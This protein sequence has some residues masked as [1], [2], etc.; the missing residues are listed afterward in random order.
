MVLRIAYRKP[1]D[2]VYW[3]QHLHSL[4]VVRRAKASLSK[5]MPDQL[6]L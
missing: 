2:H 1:I 3:R 5:G 6:P 4:G